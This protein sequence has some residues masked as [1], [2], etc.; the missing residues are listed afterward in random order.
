MTDPTPIETT[1]VQPTEEQL[2]YSQR[3]YR[4]N[5]AKM[6]AANRAWETKNK[7]RKNRLN[8]GCYKRN[9]EAFN[10]AR[11]AVKYNTTLE[12][13]QAMLDANPVCQICGKGPEPGKTLFIDHDHNTWQLRGVLCHRCNCGI[14]YF[15]DSPLILSQ[16]IKYLTD[17]THA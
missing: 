1:T 6:L 3:Y 17:R 15:L 7:D 11:R 9:K 2:T 5:R 8:R 12:V 13:V 10:I 4:K 16:A 14:G